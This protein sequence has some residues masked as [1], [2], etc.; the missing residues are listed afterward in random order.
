MCTQLCML[1]VHEARNCLR[2]EEGSTL[3][4]AASMFLAAVATGTAQQSEPGGMGAQMGGEAAGG[5]IRGGRP[6][7]GS[8][9]LEDKGR[10]GLDAATGGGPLNHFSRVSAIVLLSSPRSNDAPKRTTACNRLQFHGLR[11]W[12]RSHHIRSFMSLVDVNVGPPSATAMVEATVSV[13]CY[14][15]WYNARYEPDKGHSYNTYIG[16][17]SSMCEHLTVTAR[18]KNWTMGERTPSTYQ[19]DKSRSLNL[20]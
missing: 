1:P 10:D 8:R 20:R 7:E 5:L 16:W 15:N 3:Q 18:L 17:G 6:G 11:Q 2:C 12:C 14:R 9:G 4:G 13:S 19:N